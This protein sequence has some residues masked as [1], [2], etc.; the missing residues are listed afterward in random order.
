MRCRWL[1]VVFALP[2]LVG[3]FA[4]DLEGFLP[5][6]TPTAMIDL[7]LTT[8]DPN[9]EPVALTRAAELT[10]TPLIVENIT[11]HPEQLTPCG[12]RWANEE[13]PDL[14]EAGQSALDEARVPGEVL[15]YAFGEACVGGQGQQ[16]DML[17]METDIRVT[18]QVADLE[19]YETMGDLAADAL[20]AL[21]SFTPEN[22]PGP[23]PGRFEL[24]FQKGDDQA[25]VLV[26][27]A[28]AVRYVD[29][30]LRGESLMIALLA[31]G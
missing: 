11:P 8:P 30:G 23:M 18:F 15:I 12:Y 5:T 14:T 9:L 19:D 20:T 21:I 27:Y 4:M 6:P 1:I 24:W 17:I 26:Y 31:E 16:T 3:C 29:E 25:A 10:L 13:L 2:L 28:D 7:L 22:T